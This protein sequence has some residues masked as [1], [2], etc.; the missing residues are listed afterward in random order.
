MG[1]YEWSLISGPSMENAGSMENR[2]NQTLSLNDLQ[3]GVYQFKVVVSGGNPPVEGEGFGNV[4]ILPPER[5]NQTPKAVLNPPT[6]TVLLP[7]KQAII[8]ASGST[9]DT[10]IKDLTYKWE[11]TSSPVEF[12]QELP[13]LQLITLENL[14]PG[15]Y[16]ITVTITD[17]DGASDSAI[18][19]LQVIEE[20]DY[21]PSAN[22]GEDVV[23][24]LPNNQVVLHGNQSSDDHGIV[25][26]E[27]TL[28][29][30][31]KKLAADT[32]DMRT[33]F[34]K[35]SNLE[36]GTYSFHLKVTDSKGQSSE[37]DMS[38]Y[39]KPPINQ[40]PIAKAGQNR[41]ISLPKNWVVLDGSESHDDV[42]ITS[43]LWIQVSGPN[44][45]SFAFANTSKT[46]A[47]SLTKGTYQFKLTVKDKD[48][49][50]D[51][52][53]VSVTVNQDSNAAPVAQAGTDVEVV[54]PQS[55]VIVNGSASHDDLR[56]AKWRWTRDPK[57]LAA[58]KILGNSSHEP[59]LYLVNLVPGHYIFDLKVWDDQGKSSEDAISIHVKDNPNKNNVI[60]AIL[61]ANLTSLTHNQVLHFIQ[62]VNL[63]LKTEESEPKVKILN[64]IQQQHTNYAMLQFHVE[65]KDAED[66][67]K[68]KN[69][70]KIVEELKNKLKDTD[71]IIGLKMI[72]L[73]TLVCQND[74]SGHG[75]CR[76][77]TRSCVCESFWI[78]N[79]I[80]RNAMDGKSNCE[81]S[82]I[83][84]GIFISFLLAGT[85][86]GIVFLSCKKNKKGQTGANGRSAR[87]RKRY[88]RLEQNENNFE[89]RNAHTSSLMISD[90]DSDNEE[91]IIFDDDL[92][93]QK[94]H[95]SGMNG[96]SL[97]SKRN[98]IITNH[99]QPRA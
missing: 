1:N 77:D 41:T 18:A 33:E 4:T 71:D 61:D 83:Y 73:D 59:V 24:Y 80:R 27:W 67:I 21:P 6:Q 87:S 31:D 29:E 19:T 90:S 58:G 85:I 9:D 60:Q 11:I 64:I 50:E 15:N 39:V 48:G 75:H 65:L 72:E 45:A 37:D 92:N 46:N 17:P 20:K 86:C 35:I 40:P 95:Q 26:W 23:V 32:K 99:N 70:L 76:Q 28:N 12:K 42:G 5:I 14:L 53:Y 63:L 44:Q 55:V 78:E 69:G 36:E 8:D 89:L 84:V 56:I 98:G 22:A 30:G 81:W 52:K 74:C 25:S 3:E 66:N 16:T 54:L 79:F 62:G 97:L 91:E 47:T 7:T 38:V 10:D 93:R 49:N 51:S 82:V 57:S 88:T 94:I 68:I 34:P 13:D 43:Y 96:G 2:Q